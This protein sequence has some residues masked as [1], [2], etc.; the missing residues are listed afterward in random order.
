MQT[1]SRRRRLVALGERR[2]DLGRDVVD[3]VAVSGR[4]EV[5]DDEQGR[6]S[7]RGLAVWRVGTR[8][9]RRTMESD[10]ICGLGFFFFHILVLQCKTA[11]F[12]SD[13]LFKKKKL[14]NVVL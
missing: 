5:E 6:Q 11:S 14:N 4:E 10:R 8:S 9:G 1:C 7:S 13:N 12:C 3:G 2:I